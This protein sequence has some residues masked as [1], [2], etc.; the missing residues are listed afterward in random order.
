MILPVEELL[1]KNLR[2]KV[3]VFETDT[4]YGIGCLFDDLA[5]VK[6]IFE[7]KNREYQKPMA[8]LCADTTQVQ[9]LVLDYATID[10]YA[11]KYWPGA[12][13]LICQKNSQ[14]DDLVTAGGKTVGVRIPDN[15]LAQKILRHFGPLVTTSLNQSGEPA[16]LK[17]AEALKYE[18]IVDFVVVGKDLS[19]L[20]STVFDPAKKVTIR[21]G[22]IHISEE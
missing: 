3:V 11:R 13:T 8:I 12:L 2:G 19:A 21:Q 9:R 7:I 1:K 14:V 17:Y 4:V 20:A 6:R 22:A 15:E 10:K 16:I 18:N 5:S